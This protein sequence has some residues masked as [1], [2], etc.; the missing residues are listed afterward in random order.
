MGWGKKLIG[1][2]IAYGATKKL[3]QEAKKK[4]D[5][6]SDSGFISSI[7]PGVV[8]QRRVCGGKRYTP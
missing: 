5:E 2:A 6:K 8:F 3:I 4:D 7:W 1:G